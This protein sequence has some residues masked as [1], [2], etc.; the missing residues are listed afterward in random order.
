MSL[1]RDRLTEKKLVITAEVSPPK[2][3]GIKKLREHIQLISP[4]VTAINI[5]DCQRAIVRM[6]SWAACKIIKDLGAEPVLQ[7]TCRDRNSIAIQADLMGASALGIQNVLCLTGD[8]VKVGDSPDSRSVFEYESIKL[9]QTASNLQI[10]R[11]AQNLKMNA[12]TRFF[13]GTA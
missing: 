8:P 9:L 13:L 10:G 7:V 2:G 1:L 12:P 11:D 6:A 3:A 4:H 5:T